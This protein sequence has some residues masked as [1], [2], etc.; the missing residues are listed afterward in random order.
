MKISFKLAF[1]V[2]ILMTFILQAQIG[3]SS[4]VAVNQDNSGF[5]QVDLGPG[6]NN[7][8]LNFGYKFSNSTQESNYTSSTSDWSSV[9]GVNSSSIF[10]SITADTVAKYQVITLFG[11]QTEVGTSEVQA[12]KDGL[13][14]GKGLLYL[15]NSDNASIA[16]QKFFDDLFG[17]PV[18]NFTMN[19]VMGNSYSGLVPYVVSNEFSSP[20]TPIT[21][22]V[23]KLVFP[24][25][26]GININR[27]AI[28]ETNMT[29]KDIYPIVVDSS[30]RQAIGVA[31]E[32]GFYGR[33]IIL[34]S[35]EVFSNQLYSQTGVYTH[36]QGVSNQLF[37]LNAISWLGRITGYFHMLSHN[38]N[39]YPLQQIT[40][41]L[42]INASVVLTNNYNQS[43]KDVEVRFII[44]VTKSVVD[45]NYMT[46][47]GNNTYF[48]SIS[49]KDVKIGNEI[50]INVQLFKR[51]FVPQEFPLSRVYVKLEFKGPALPDLSILT[52]LIASIIIYAITAAYIWSEYKKS[53]L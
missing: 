39:V 42:V 43:L 22:N 33:I 23:T 25:T 8:E 41:G 26:V 20:T 31:I 37:G 49:T 24:H 9:F 51:G 48:G 52:I 6:F 53:G 5:P 29:I 4:L 21:A 35:S 34:G 16:A 28:S 14:Q 12:I 18:V 44:A 30:S 50:D 10:G 47:N 17:V 32:L 3:S 38:L 7:T 27:T 15:A 40:R 2:F 1:S 36:M 45:Y 13:N 11:S 46:Y 19:E